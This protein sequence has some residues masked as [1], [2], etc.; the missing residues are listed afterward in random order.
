MSPALRS[1]SASPPHTARATT[2]QGAPSF[3][4]GKIT[5]TRFILF[6]LHVSPSSTLISCAEAMRTPFPVLTR[7]TLAL[8]V[9]AA[10]LHSI[11]VLVVCCFIPVRGQHD[12][13]K[14]SI[15]VPLSLID[16]IVSG[17]LHALVWDISKYRLFYAEGRNHR[18]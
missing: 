16:C 11:L 2:L 7:F 9:S 3:Y 1:A 12:Y 17:P 6:H 14:R 8:L 5:H 18:N 13:S 10:D 15:P 4:D